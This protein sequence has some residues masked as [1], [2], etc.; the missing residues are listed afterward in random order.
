MQN[1]ERTND[2]LENKI[3]FRTSCLIPYL[4]MSFD[5]PFVRLFGVR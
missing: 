5:F 3:L 1:K 4:L 2:I